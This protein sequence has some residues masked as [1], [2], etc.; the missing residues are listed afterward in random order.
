M[1]AEF[2]PQD[3]AAFWG[4]PRF[5]ASLANARKTSPCV[6]LG[7]I[8]RCAYSFQSGGKCNPERW[9]HSPKR[10]WVT[11][12][13]TGDCCLVSECFLLRPPRSRTRSDPRWLSVMLLQH[14]I[15][16]CFSLGSPSVYCW[17][18]SEA[19]VTTDPT[20]ACHM[21]HHQIS[22]P[23]FNRVSH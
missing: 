22:F 6:P 11:P 4:P 10:Q 23:S 18:E 17:H 13:N 3:I 8:L 19:A 15:S 9:S 1:T 16:S 7:K 20:H 2:L 12:G 14:Q 5:L 21:C